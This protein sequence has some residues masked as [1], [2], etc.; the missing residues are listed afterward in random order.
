MAA[1]MQYKGRSMRIALSLVGLMS[2]SLLFGATLEKLSIEE[3]SQKS[4]VILRGR[5]A[6]CAGDQRGSVIYTRCKVQ[7][8]ERWK[9]S[10]ASQIDFLI[11]G[12]TARGL[13]QTFTGTPKF[14]AGD[15]YVLFLWAGRSGNLQVIGLS[16]GIFDVNSGDKAVMVKRAAS[17]ETMIDKNGQSVRDESVEMTAEALRRR[18]ALA[19]GEASK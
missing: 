7:V 3:M 11:P 12:G 8:M 15:E 5:I 14:N 1:Q 16:Q 4:T 17:S 19:L 2:C 13:T 9:G 6:G 10:A 18:V